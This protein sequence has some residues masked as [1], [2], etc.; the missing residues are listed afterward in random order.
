VAT[1]AYFFFFFA[2]FFFAGISL[3]PPL[4]V[5]ESSAGDRSPSAHENWESDRSALPLLR[6]PCYFFFFPFLAAFFFAGILQI[7]PFG[8]GMDKSGPR[9]HGG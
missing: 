2:A 6:Q 4:N 3:I 9:Q 1:A 8:P 5:Q 7:P